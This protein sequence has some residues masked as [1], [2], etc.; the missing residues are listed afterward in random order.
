MYWKLLRKWR[1]RETLSKN[2]EQMSS[3]RKMKMPMVQRCICTWDVKRSKR[4]GQKSFD[5]LKW[6]RCNDIF[7]RQMCTSNA[8]HC[9]N[10]NAIFEGSIQRKC[11]VTRSHTRLTA[12]KWKQNSKNVFH[13]SHRVV[14]MIYEARDWRQAIDVDQ[15][16][17]H[18][19]DARLNIVAL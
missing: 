1:E 14:I 4:S 5:R 13:K 18:T 8:C 10:K 19:C 17:A 16:D 9:R 2:T 3:H 6:H 15:S 7:T 12:K 11:H